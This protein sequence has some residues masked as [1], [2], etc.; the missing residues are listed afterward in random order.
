MLAIAIFFLYSKF[1]CFVI[2]ACFLLRLLDISNYSLGRYTAEELARRNATVHL[3]CRD[4]ERGKL[5]LDEIQ[6][7]TGNQFVHLHVVD[8]SKSSDVKRFA[9]EF[10]HSGSPLDVLVNNAG[11]MPPERQITEDGLELCFGTMLLQTYLLTTL[12]LPSMRLS[13]SSRVINIS[14]GTY[15]IHTV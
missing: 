4:A 9:E 8:L 1:I 13:S 7:V 6:A 14:S 15:F 2:I 11:L 10:V 12:L 3:L 5:A